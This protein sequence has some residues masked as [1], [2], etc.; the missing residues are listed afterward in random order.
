[1]PAFWLGL[2]LALL[3]PEAWPFL[4][5][6]GLWLVWR[7]RATLLPVAIGLATLPLL[8]LVPEEIGSGDWLRAAHR[9]Q[10]PISGSPAD[11]ANP[12]VE[13]VREGWDMLGG[14]SWLHWGLLAG[15]AAALGCA[16]AA[17]WPWPRWPPPGRW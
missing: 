4:G 9:A 8:W 13:V 10:D 7:E 5:L 3:R 17:C 6:Y 15:V 1:M 12:I 11:A 2:G 14:G 16:T